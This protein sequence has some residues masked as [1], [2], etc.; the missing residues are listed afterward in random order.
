MHGNAF[1]WLSFVPG[2]DVGHYGHVFLAILI[3]VLLLVFTLIARVQL[4]AAIKREDQGLVPDSK[5]TIRNFFEIIAEALY[6]LAVSVMGKHNAER[7]FPLIATL[8]IF[9]LSC[10]LVGM[11]PG[12]LPPTENLNTTLSFG[13]FVFIYYTAVGIKDSGLGYFKHFF[14][15]VW[16]LAWLIFPIEIA[17]NLFRPISLALRLR[18]NIMGDHVVLGVFNELTH[19]GVPIIFYAMG[20]F[21]CL[22]QAFVFCLLTMVYIS[23]ASHHEE[24]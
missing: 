15:P 17:S 9:I 12:L 8:F 2:L 24:H 4:N 11:I 20:L 7:H 3:M 16:W 22:I 5:L 10:N 14:G 21:V 13:L 23:L 18:G 6:D 1:N 19:I